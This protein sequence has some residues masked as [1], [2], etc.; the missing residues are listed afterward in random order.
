MQCVSI[1]HDTARAEP[2]ARTHLGDEDVV[3]E[4][5]TR[6]EAELVAL[7]LAAAQAASAHRAPPTERCAQSVRGRA[8]PRRR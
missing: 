3:S 4:D 2:G 6:G 7:V 8:R 5:A 1:S